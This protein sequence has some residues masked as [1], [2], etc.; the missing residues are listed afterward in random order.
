MTSGSLAWHAFVL[1]S[2]GACRA[3][4]WIRELGSRG[5][6][7]S[8]G[9]QHRRRRGPRHCPGRSAAQLRR[10]RRCRRSDHSG[11]GQEARRCA[12][13]GPDSHSGDDV[14][15]RCG[16]RQLRRAAHQRLRLGDLGHE[17]PEPDRLREWHVLQRRRMRDTVRL[18]VR[19]RVSVHPACA[20]LRLLRVGRAG[21]VGRRRLHDVSGWADPPDP[22][23][24]ICQRRRRAPDAG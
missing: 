11:P 12:S 24:A 14:G 18:R 1:P 2:A 16:D 4:R 3:D 13:G 19:T 20:A 17:L 23:P 10:D 7:R 15:V 8:F 21:N 6:R 22:A 9:T 5:E